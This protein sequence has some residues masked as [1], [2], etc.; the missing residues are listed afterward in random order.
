MKS[1]LQIAVV[2]VTMASAAATTLGQPRNTPMVSGSLVSLALLKKLKR[3]YPLQ[4]Q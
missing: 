1:A 3:R 4:A 2:V